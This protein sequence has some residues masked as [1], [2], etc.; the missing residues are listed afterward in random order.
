[1]ADWWCWT[2]A[3]CR[4]KL[5]RLQLRLG[6]ASLDY[7]EPITQAIPANGER[8][9]RGHGDGGGGGAPASSRTVLALTKGYQRAREEAVRCWGGGGAMAVAEE[10]RV[11]AIVGTGAGGCYGAEAA[12]LRAKKKAEKE[13]WRARGVSGRTRGGNGQLWP[14]SAARGRAL[15]TRGQP[16]RPR[17]GQLLRPVDHC[18]FD[19]VRYGEAS[20][21]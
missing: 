2:T 17:G 20:R 14:G 6:R 21:A 16:R 1:M 15:A 4:W 3:R 13:K 12:L 11:R 8:R 7:G 9:R 18:R 19:S 10:Q 5:R